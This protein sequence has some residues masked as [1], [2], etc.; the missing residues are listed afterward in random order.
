V[1]SSS[2]PADKGHIVMLYATG[3]GQTTPGGVDGRP[4]NGIYPQPLGPV[5][6]QVNGKDA[7]VLY[8]G[9]APGLV[10]GVMQVN[11]RVPADAPSGN[12]SVVIK[13]GADSSQ[14]GATISVR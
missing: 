1:N 5:T 9:A 13:T 2:K 6:A 10:A 7:E 3:E 8:Y 14:S 11:V 12:V 4:A